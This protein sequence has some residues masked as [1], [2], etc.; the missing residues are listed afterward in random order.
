M[1]E[2][3]YYEFQ[4]IDK[5]LTAEQMAELRDISTRATITPTSFTNVYNWGDLKANPYEL[6]AEYFD[7]FL[8]LANSGTRELMFR[9]PRRILDAETAEAYCA[10]ESAAANTAGDS[11]ILLF[12]SENEDGE[13]Q[14]SGEGWLSSL[15]PLRADILAGDLRCLYL[16]WLLCAQDHTLDDDELEPV[17]P[18]SCPSLRELTG[19]LTA[20]AEFLRLDPDL[21]AVAAAGM[22]DPADAAP[23]PG[24]LS[25]WI[26]SLPT[27]AKDEMLVRVAEGEAAG[28]RWELLKRFRAE[29]AAASPAASQEPP[30]RTVAQ[31][32]GLRDEKGQER[33]QREAEK[34]AAEAARRAKAVA[35]ARKKHLDSLA[36]R[37]SE[38]W[39]QIEALIRATQPKEYDQ[40]VRLLVDLRDLASRDGTTDDFLAALRQLRERHNRK[41]SLLRRL[42]KA[43][44]AE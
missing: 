43:G 31:L 7:A 38:L 20:F 15:I 27:P 12:S 11:T 17:L 29:R 4:A 36:G 8:Y 10:G 23:K 18:A 2:Y 24:E 1:S 26:H 33:R 39:E 25:A 9:F 44:L 28:L 30:R 6:V 34:Q 14:H 3:Q 22:P 32:L 37:E 13:W 41:P 35:L 42:V 5:P 19:P 16:G 21:I 40:A